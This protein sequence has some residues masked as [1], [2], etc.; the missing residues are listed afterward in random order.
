MYLIPAWPILGPSFYEV[1]N[2]FYDLTNLFYDLTNLY[3]DL[4]NLFYDVTNLYYDV[5]NL[6]YN[7][8]N[9][10]YDVTNLYPSIPNGWSVPTKSTPSPQMTPST[11]IQRDYNYVFY[12]M[13]YASQVHFIGGLRKNM[14]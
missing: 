3:Y 14:V 7:V 5:T 12:M 1:T 6:Y 8:T 2:L 4:T 10:F 11:C 9:L 13:S